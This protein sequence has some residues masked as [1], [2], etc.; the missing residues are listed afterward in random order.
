[1]P[2]AN[3]AG[4]ITTT[5]P[6]DQKNV[7]PDDATDIQLDNVI[8]GHT[9]FPRSFI[10]NLD[11]TVHLQNMNGDTVITPVI[12]GAEYVG[13]FRRFLTASVTVTS[14]TVKS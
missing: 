10:P 8:K 4:R 2:D 13:M 5:P 9:K 12:K 7:T 14:L 3:I 1:M 6:V 11:G